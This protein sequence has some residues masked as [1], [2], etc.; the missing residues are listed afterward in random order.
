[1]PANPAVDTLERILFLKRS[2]QM[3][4]LSAEELSAVAEQMRERSFQRGST[5]LREGEPVGAL[6]C[7]VEGRVR[8]SRRGQLLGQV[9]PGAFLGGLGILARDREGIEVVA[10]ADV[11]ALELDADTMLE[12]FEDHYSILQQVIRTTARRLLDL[13][14]RSPEIISDFVR[15]HPEALKTPEMNLVE[16]ML[17]L[18]QV[19]PFKMSSVNALAELSHALKQVTFDPGKVLWREGDPSGDD[20]LLVSGTVLCTGRG[21]AVRFRAGSGTPLGTLESVAGG[22][23]W[24]TAVTETNVVA[25]EENLEA[26]FDVFEDN[27][28]MAMDYV[29]AVSRNTLDFIERAGRLELFD[30]N[31]GEGEVGFTTHHEAHHETLEPLGS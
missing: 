11:L 14:L 9:G 6:Y 13:V 22:K 7:I 20:L 10:E 8:A 31:P 1:M 24:H 27:F 26:L 21:D 17:F 16:R 12:I 28:E 18:R 25:L 2:L 4:G 23:R 5:L 3:K 30:I 19:G 15:V 29:A